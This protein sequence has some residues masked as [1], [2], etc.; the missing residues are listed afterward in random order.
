MLLA[1]SIPAREPGGKTVVVLHGRGDSIEGFRF[2]PEAIGNPRLA[3]RLLNAPDRYYTGWSWYDL[4]PNQGPG[5][6]RS[7][8]LI[9]AEL[10]ALRAQ[11]IA[12]EDLIL[13]GFSQGCL[14]SIDVALRYPHRLGGVCGISG[15]MHFVERL[16]EAV[17]EAKQTAWLIT[18]GVH[19]DLLP[20]E[21]TRAAVEALRGAGIPV[22][23]HEFEKDHTIDPRDELPLLRRWFADRVRERKDVL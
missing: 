12:S 8:A 6:L 22:E 20:I 17:P 23:W 7:R 5:V 13:F 11:G 2:L 18:H 14:M 10:D 1:E 4:P 16:H 9:T 19:D 15:Y 21:N 3:Y